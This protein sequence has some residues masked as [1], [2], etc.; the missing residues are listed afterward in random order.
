MRL[1]GTHLARMVADELRVF[2][3]AYAQNLS[4]QVVKDFQ[5]YGPWSPPAVLLAASVIL[6][7]VSSSEAAL[8]SLAVSALFDLGLHGSQSNHVV[9]EALVTLAVLL[10]APNPLIGGVRDQR[11][12][13][14]S[15]RLTLA[16]RGILVM[17]YAV[18]GFAKLNDG[19]HDPR[20]SC[21]VHMLVGVVGFFTPGLV[22]Y[23]PSHLLQLL[24]YGATAFELSF[25]LVLVGALACG[26]VSARR[27]SRVLRAL[28]IGGCA[29]HVLIA[30]PPPPISVYPFSM[31]MVPIYIHALLPHHVG[32]AARAVGAW[33]AAMRTAAVSVFAAAGGI[34]LALHSASSRFEYPPYFS[35]ELGV[36]W[37]VA[38]FGALAAVAVVSSGAPTP[39]TPAA[40]WMGRGRT[41]L[42]LF[43]AVLLVAISSGTYLG[44]RTYPSFAMFSNLLI[45]GNASNH[46]IVRRPAALAEWAHKSGLGPQW[47]YG[48]HAAIEILHTDLPALRELQ[49]NLAPLLP[50]HVLAALSAA[51]ASAEFHISPPAWPYPPTEGV[52]RPFSVPLVE[53]RR[54]LSAAVRASPRVSF[55][56]RYRVVGARSKALREYR[57][58]DGQRT[59]GSD[60]SL[61]EELPPLRAM[62]H[63]YRTFDAA[64]A[65]CRH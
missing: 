6:V 29:F 27:P 62:L 10:T 22:R 11:R 20:Y 2:A 7:H 49:V 43:P 41:V 17:L 18:T 38:A 51:N 58:R 24:P 19:W 45:E 52:F 39:A 59:R 1:L 48:P 64:Y 13:E 26:G 55:V 65:P 57:R 44:V 53:V 33:P 37:T 25:P 40:P 4:L 8:L 42:A 36:L 21:C 23:M 14:W 15:A 12:A 35:W 56:V 46:W 34:A 47:Q 63:R 9:L 32:A 54:R 30:L 3:L 5:V 60:A 61:D 50:A 31:L 28:T 16:M